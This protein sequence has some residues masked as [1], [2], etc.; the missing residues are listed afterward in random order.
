MKRFRP[1]ASDKEYGQ[2]QSLSQVLDPGT[3]RQRLLPPVRLVAVT[4]Q[5]ES[6]PEERMCK[7]GIVRTIRRLPLDSDVTRA[8][9]TLSAFCAAS[10][11]RVAS[12]DFSLATVAQAARTRAVKTTKLDAA[13]PLSFIFVV[14]IHL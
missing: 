8:A 5:N 11:S 6:R 3:R 10:S 13:S 7:P 4:D 9:S 14:Q 1:K 12:A 2:V